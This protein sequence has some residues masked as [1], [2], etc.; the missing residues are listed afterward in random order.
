MFGEKYQVVHGAVPH[1]HSRTW[2]QRGTSRHNV[3]QLGTAIRGGCREK[4]C[5]RGV[6][7]VR[8]TAARR[9]G[10][11]GRRRWRVWGGVVLRVSLPG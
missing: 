6:G 1:R 4:T 7:R 5:N 2:A 11:R 10:R 9:G 3:A 8:E